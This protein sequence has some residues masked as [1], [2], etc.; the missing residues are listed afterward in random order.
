[1]HIVLGILRQ[2]I[3]DYMGDPLDVEPTGG[4]IGGH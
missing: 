1:V 3:I 2:V 4:N